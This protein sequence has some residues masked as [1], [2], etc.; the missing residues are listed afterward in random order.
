MN[1]RYTEELEL[2]LN[3]HTIPVIE[4]ISEGMPG[5]FFIYHADDNE[6]LI[7]FNKAMLRIF[8]CD[9]KEEFRQFTGNTF[10]GIVHPEDYGQVEKSIEKQVRNSF[11]HLDYVEYRIIRK[12]GMIR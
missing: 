6:E 10:R 7:F 9:S 2:E 12:D 11:Y 1:T 4:Q 3:E 8:G 5:G